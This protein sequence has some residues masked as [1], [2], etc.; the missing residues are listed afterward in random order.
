MRRRVH[1][2]SMDG[3]SSPK[4]ARGGQGSEVASYSKAQEIARSMGFHLHKTG[5]PSAFASGDGEPTS[6]VMSSDA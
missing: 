4:M 5:K 6:L 1:W 2:E 3:E